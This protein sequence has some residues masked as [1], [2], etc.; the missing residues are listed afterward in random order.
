MKHVSEDEFVLLYYRDAGENEMREVESHIAVCGEC[1]KEFERVRSLLGA[2]DLPVPEPPEHYARDV[3]RKLRPALS[4]QKSGNWFG[5]FGSL[6]WATAITMAA[7]ILAA[8]TIGRWFER[9]VEIGRI[10]IPRQT[11]SGGSVQL[12]ARQRALLIAVGGH[13]ERAQIVLSEL[14]N[15]KPAR[16]IDISTE[17]D[18][19]QALLPD[20]RLYRATAL[21]LPD[22]KIANLLDELERLLVD[23]S[24]RPSVVSTDE[25]DD[26]REQI[27]TR[28]ILFKVRI[29]GSELRSRQ[30]N[31]G[32]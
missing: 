21:Q 10:N 27:D 23:L 19:V 5:W 2:I 9:Q 16:Q 28:G 13:L 32:L 22:V 31:A 29:A 30:R 15:A 12:A 8:F 24:H 6:K 18:A 25:L 26:I 7:I 3:W 4:D 11:T 1:R 17:Q 20:N 14:A